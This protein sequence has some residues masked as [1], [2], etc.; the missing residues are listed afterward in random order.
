[1][2][3]EELE[4]KEQEEFVYLVVYKVLSVDLKKQT[5]QVLN[6]VRHVCRT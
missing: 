2:L 1:M 6:K 3:W 4:E 5:V